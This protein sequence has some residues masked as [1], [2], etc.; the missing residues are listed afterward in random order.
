MKP[1][2]IVLPPD[3]MSLNGVT[4]NYSVRRSERAKHIR[5][6]ISPHSGVVVTIPS[7]TRRYINPEQFLREKQEW[8]LKHITKI[9]AC[10]SSNP[11]EL[12]NGSVVNLQGSSYTFWVCRREVWQPQI[13]LAGR[14][15]RLH[16]PANFKGDTKE[17][18][19]AW[20]KNRAA[21]VI[22]GETDQLAPRIGVNYTNVSIRDQKTKWGSCSRKGN[23]SF[24]WRLI[25]FPHQVL[26]YVVIHEL[27][28]LRH[29]NHSPRF[30]SLVERHDPN[31]RESIEW[32][33]EHGPVMDG[34]LR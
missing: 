34:P 10:Q 16:V 14:E 33:K 27:C 4:V 24:N 11:Q 28:H 6:T 5:I 19:K 9:G 29:F 12:E 17:T 3:S 23:L 22:R 7:R 25:L 15:L 26:R 18:V 21:T 2:R 13:E 31:Y 32:L 20:V 1:T 8:V 30:W